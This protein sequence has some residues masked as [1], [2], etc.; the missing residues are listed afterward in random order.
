[1]FRDGKH[2]FEYI[3]KEKGVSN[4][5]LEHETAQIYTRALR[6]L[7]W[8]CHQN[9]PL[10]PPR[11]SVRFLL[12][13]CVKR[14]SQTQCSAPKVVSFLCGRSGFL[15]LGKLSGWVRINTVN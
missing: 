12:Q 2:L 6:E 10:S 15:R 8:H 1:M 14:V 7:L 11:L 13:T 9:K 3:Q 4:S 5:L